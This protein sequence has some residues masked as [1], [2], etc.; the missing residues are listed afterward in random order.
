MEA[1]RDVSQVVPTESDGPPSPQSVFCSRVTQKLI[2][3][4]APPLVEIDAVVGAVEHVEAR[5]KAG[6]N[7]VLGQNRSG[8]GV[9]GANGRFIHFGHRVGQPVCP[10]LLHG[11]FPI[12]PGM[13]PGHAGCCLEV[14]ADPPA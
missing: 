1:E 9:E 11:P 3:K 12:P 10:H 4:P 2:E 13:G 5:G 14:L 8:E 6:C 7:A